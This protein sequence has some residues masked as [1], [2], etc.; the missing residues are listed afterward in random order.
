MPESRDEFERIVMN[1]SEAEKK[2]EQLERLR[3][4]LEVHTESNILSVDVTP[5]QMYINHC[6]INMKKR[7]KDKVINFILSCLQERLFADDSSQDDIVIADFLLSELSKF[8][9]ILQ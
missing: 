9:R 1:M 8:Y 4:F 6:R 2:K 3:R 7:E 5:L